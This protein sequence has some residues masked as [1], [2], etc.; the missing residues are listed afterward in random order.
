MGYFTGTLSNQD[1]VIDALQAAATSSGWTIHRSG[2]LGTGDSAGKEL[3]LSKGTC[4]IAAR[5]LVNLRSLWGLPT[6]FGQPCV[7]F[8]A[9]TSYDAGAAWDAQPNTWP[10]GN[11]T[12]NY[13]GCYIGPSPSGA[14]PLPNMSYP[15]PYRI[16]TFSNP[17]VIL[18]VIRATATVYQWVMFGHAEKFGTWTGGEFVAASNSPQYTGSATAAPAF[19]LAGASNIRTYAPFHQT[20][21]SYNNGFTAFSQSNSRMRME[22]PGDLPRNRWSYTSAT[23][24]YVGGMFRWGGSAGWLADPINSRSPNSLNQIGVMSPFWIATQRDNQ[25]NYSIVA[26]LAHIRQ[27]PIDN[28]NPEDTF[29]LGPDKWIVFPYFEKGGVTGRYG[30]AINANEIP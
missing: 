17:D 2:S 1:D 26:R 30:W 8:K 29:T 25:P 21:V 4:F 15:C 19:N 10:N 12:S 6:H 28:F 13:E 20:S 3:I 18:M 22:I 14:N 5:S 27:I 7:A 11:S 24:A 9:A 23:D 16:F